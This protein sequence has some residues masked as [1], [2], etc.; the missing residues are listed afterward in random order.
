[1]YSVIDLFLILFSRP[2]DIYF[3]V[4]YAG[5]RLKFGHFQTSNI[6]MLDTNLPVVPA[7][8]GEGV[9]TSLVSCH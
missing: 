4:Y 9:T 6:H 3:S 2:S 7:V 5:V 1:M 8:V